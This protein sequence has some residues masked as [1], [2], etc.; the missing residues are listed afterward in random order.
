MLIVSYNIRWGKGRDGQIDLRR[1]AATVDAADIIALQEV[2]RH[3]RDQE[4]PDQALRLS[5]LIP[6]YHW[7]Y[8]A[9]VDLGGPVRN[10]RRQI[11]NMVLSRY[12]I[13]SVRHLPLPAWPVPGHVNDQQQMI[14]AVITTERGFRLYN[15]HLNYLSAEQRAEQLASA[16]H[17][18]AEAPQR[19]GAIT[20]PD[21]KSLGPEDEWIVLPDGKPP[22]MPE[23]AILLGDFN[24]GPTSD[25]HHT[26]I[27]AGFSDVFAIAG[28]RPDQGITFPGREALPRQRLDHC[29]LSPEFAPRF[30]RAWIDE[31]ADGSDH[32]PVWVELDWP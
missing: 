14:E 32:Q 16:L 15:T 22:E 1:I 24:S 25:E 29:F 8:G 9:A 20:M 13:S 5:E 31:S 10:L 18:V 11:G 27:A 6:G 4:F 7:V 12:P 3:W 17:F 28:L 23:P 26:I 30:R 19:G 21:M 2:E